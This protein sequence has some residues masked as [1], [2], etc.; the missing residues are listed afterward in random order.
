MRQR[1]YSTEKTDADTVRGS[2]RVCIPIDREEYEQVVGDKKAF[3]QLLDGYIEQYPV[4]F[5][6]DI[7][8]GYKLHGRLPQSKKMPEVHLR[9][10][11]LK[12]KDAQGQAQVFTIAPCFVLP[13]MTGYTDEV[14]KALFLHEKFG[15]AFWGL[16]YVFGRNDM[17]WYRLIQDQ[18]RNSI[19][20]T[21]IKEPDK[22]PTDVLA[23]EK[24]T[25]FN[26]EKAYLALTV[27]DDCVLGASVALAADEKELTE[28]YGHFK[29]EAQQLKEDYQPQTVNTDGWLA[30][31]L[32]W[33]AL[34]P[35]IVIIRCFLHA[36]IKVSS[37]C[38]R[39]KNEFVEIQTQVWDIYHA[40]DPLTFMKNVAALKTWAL[41]TLP[42]GT[43]LNAILKLC[44][45]TPDFIKA[46]AYPSAYRTR[47]VLS[48]A[49]V[50]IIDRHI[51]P[52][53]RYLSSTK[54]FNGHLISAERSARAW[55]LS[56]NFLPYCPR[57]KVGQQYKSPAHQLNGFTYRD[58]WLENLLVSA[59]M[60]GFQP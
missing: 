58:N 9:R 50:N 33:S 49:E 15:V 54:Y 27:A 48:G 35:A 26:G 31:H 17:Y 21:T 14:E 1:N 56:H 32:A 25:D 57:A 4:L 29:E 8:Q 45:K 28:A 19:V 24:H 3:R 13:Y 20:G 51:E 30:T 60:R 23:D 55:A 37:C 34:F 36:F 44:D 39:M 42:E 38:K 10:V 41:L 47:L 2:K 59:S 6:S 22:L 7:G 53:D 16:T 5:P 52:L 11:Q 46:Y 40:A 18:G 12:A 43:G